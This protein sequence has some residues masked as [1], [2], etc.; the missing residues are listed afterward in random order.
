M[1]V[2]GMGKVQL[3]GMEA[4]LACFLSYDFLLPTPGLCHL[5]NLDRLDRWDSSYRVVDKGMVG[6]KVDISY[7]VE[8]MGG[9]FHLARHWEEAASYKM[10]TAEDI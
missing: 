2:G 8:D 4:D 3:V 9:G 5:C 6:M 7:V 1:V 10:D